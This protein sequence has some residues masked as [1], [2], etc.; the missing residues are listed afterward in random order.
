MKTITIEK[1]NDYWRVFKEYY[2]MPTTYNNDMPAA[3]VV[4]KLKALYPDTKII[5]SAWLGSGGDDMG[6]I[7]HLI[8]LTA[9]PDHAKKQEDRINRLI[10][11]GR[12]ACI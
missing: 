11:K 1:G 6:N 9:D 4:E 2:W 7:S 5:I 3:E 12:I 8:S 10:Q